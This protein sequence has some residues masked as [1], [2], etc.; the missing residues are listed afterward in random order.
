ME[1][2]YLPVRAAHVTFVCCSGALLALRGTL[3]LAGSPWANQPSV[4]RLS[5]VIDT[6]LLAAAIT[7][8]VIIRQYPFVNAWL[9]TMV[10]LLVPYILLGSYALRRARSPTA[11]AAALVA[12]LALFLYIASVAYWHNPAGIF[13]ARASVAAH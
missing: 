12:A 8:T 7:L 1:G 6:G 5:H 9:T 13:H 3:A 2:L 4:R 10:L 11:R